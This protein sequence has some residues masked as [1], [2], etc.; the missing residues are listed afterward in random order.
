[1]LD[2]AQSQL[3]PDFNVKQCSWE[4]VQRQLKQAEDEVEKYFAQAKG[5]KGILR[6]VWRKL[7]RASIVWEPGL[8]AIPDEMGLSVLKGGLALIFNVS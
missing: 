4:D 2:R 6:K 7:G 8:E 1:M 5:A 3:E